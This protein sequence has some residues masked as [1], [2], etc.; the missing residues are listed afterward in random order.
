M[1]ISGGDSSDKPLE[2]EILY[3]GVGIQIAG[4][5]RGKFSK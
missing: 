5:T 2:I 4:C 3:E 1:E